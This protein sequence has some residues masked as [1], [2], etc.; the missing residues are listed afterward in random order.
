MPAI[1]KAFTM[2]SKQPEILD[3]DDEE[4][5]TQKNVAAKCERAG[6]HRT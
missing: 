5:L 6:I 1:F 3:T 2:I 4:A